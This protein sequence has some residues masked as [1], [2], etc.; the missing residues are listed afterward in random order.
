M[1]NLNV[2][3]TILVL[4]IVLSGCRK[5]R[6]KR[7]IPPQ[8]ITQF[9]TYDCGIP[10]ARDKV[11]FRIPV[12]NV[13]VIDGQPLWTLDQNQYADLG[14]NMQDIIKAM[15]QYAE[16]VRFY[17]KCISAAQVTD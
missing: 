8:I 1:R 15:G 4:S 6:V 9:R 17:D 7:E 14:E 5:D 2:L 3:L 11:S 16:L 13:I 10:P 12:F